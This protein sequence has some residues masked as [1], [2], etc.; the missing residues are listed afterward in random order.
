[1]E[2]LVTENNLSEVIRKARPQ[3]LDKSYPSWLE[4]AE[5]KSCKHGCG[6]CQHCGERYAFGHCS[7]TAYIG[8]IDQGGH[9]LKA[10][11]ALHLMKYEYPEWRNMTDSEVEYGLESRAEKCDKN[12]WTIKEYLK[13]TNDMLE[14]QQPHEDSK[15]EINL[16]VCGR[17]FFDSEEFEAHIGIN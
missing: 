5:V 15:L 11:M 2:K 9:Q 17:K 13:F 1:M 4:E 7:D 3:F 16:C 14:T 10:H 6:I 8:S 12:W